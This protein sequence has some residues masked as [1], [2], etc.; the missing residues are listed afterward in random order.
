V[1]TDLF[2]VF[3][4][5]LAGLAFPSLINAF[6]ESRAPKAAFLLFAVSG[7]MIAVAISQKPSGYSFQEIPTAFIRVFSMMVN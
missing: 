6:S 3:G 5:V 1:D 7:V 2:L 4:L